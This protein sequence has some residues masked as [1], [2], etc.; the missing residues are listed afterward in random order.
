[1][2]REAFYS[3][4]VGGC[5]I[6]IVMNILETPLGQSLVAGIV[7]F[8]GLMAFRPLIQRAYRRLKETR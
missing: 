2:N 8:V 7:M 1:M 4:I 3:G 6:F 5:S